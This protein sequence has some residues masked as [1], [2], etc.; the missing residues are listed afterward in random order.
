MTTNNALNSGN[1]NGS[2]DFVNRFLFAADGTT[3]V[4]EWDAGFI[5]DNVAGGTPCIGTND[6][7]LYWTDGATVAFDWSAGILYNPTLGNGHNVINLYNNLIIDNNELDS[8]DW[9]NRVLFANDGSTHNI[10]YSS[11]TNV[12]LKTLSVGGGTVIKS[13][14]TAT[15]S[16]T[17]STLLTLLSND[18]TITVTGAAVNDSVILGEPAA[19]SA[20]LCFNAFVSAANTVTI[21]AFNVTAGTIIPG[22]QTFRVT[23]LHY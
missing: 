6:R 11:S 10:D 21:R 3:I 9:V 8:I 1:P 7:N 15:A 18:Q 2:I 22:A 17:F 19:P 23:V 5:C 13:I 16:I 20:G 12:A 4:Y 14:L